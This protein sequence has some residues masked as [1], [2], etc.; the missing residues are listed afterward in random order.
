MRHVVK[1]AVPRQ[2]PTSLLHC[3]RTPHGGGNKTIHPLPRKIEI[4]KHN[5]LLTRWRQTCVIYP[6]AEISHWNG[7]VNGALEFWKNKLGESELNLKYK[8]RVGDVMWVTEH[9]AVFVCLEMLLH[10]ASHYCCIYDVTVVT[11]F[12]RK[13]KS[14]CIQPPPKKKEK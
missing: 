14:Y 4:K 9:V 1:T 7:L 10:T 12:T 13:H 6:S 3:R 2:S 5:S 8:I 11:V